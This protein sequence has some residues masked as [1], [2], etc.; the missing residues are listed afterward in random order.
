MGVKNKLGRDI[1]IPKNA[2]V[3]ENPMGF[4]VQYAV[5]TIEVLIG[6]GKS[7]TASLIMS[8]EAWVELN[9]YKNDILV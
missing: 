3:L 2:E 6:I 4:K 9:K 5:E 1:N 8:K 7:H